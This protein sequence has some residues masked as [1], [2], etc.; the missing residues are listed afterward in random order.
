MSDGIHPPYFQEADGTKSGWF[1]SLYQYIQRRTNIISVSASY[2]V[3]SDVFWVRADATAGPVTITLPASLPWRGRQVGVIK[4][5]ASANTVT[6]ASAGGGDIINGGVSLALDARYDLALMIADGTIH[7]DT[8]TQTPPFSLGPMSD[9]PLVAVPFYPGAPSASAC[10]CI[11]T[12]PVGIP[13]LTFSAALAGSS[14]KALTAATAQADLD[15]RKNA[16]TAANGT[17]VGLIRF[18]AGATVPT[19]IAASGFT[20]T[21]GTDWLTIW[22][23]AVPDATLANIS[24]SLYCTRAF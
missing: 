14:G 4:T 1:S 22:A 24:S 11:F 7:W 18:A 23:P 13:L 12:A 2:S 15:V 20:L 10:M 16:N 3:L 9:Q 21:G 17:S 19:F 6:I 5:D 8:L